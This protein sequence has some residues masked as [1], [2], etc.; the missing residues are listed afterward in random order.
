[1]KQRMVKNTFIITADKCL[2][3]S[4]IFIRC[5]SNEYIKYTSIVLISHFT[6]FV[7]S[8]VKTTLILNINKLYCQYKS[9]GAILYFI[10]L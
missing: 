2:L 10:N 7:I 3:M 5:L 9:D 1:M 8:G 4:D 6:N